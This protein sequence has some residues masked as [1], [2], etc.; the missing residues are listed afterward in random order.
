M[1]NAN[2]PILLVVIALVAVA[3]QFTR[4]SGE[5]PEQTALRQDMLA[6][7]QL[8][9]NQTGSQVELVPAGERV[10]VQA[11]VSMPPNLR[12]RQQRWN[13]PFL[14]FVALRHP[15][16]RLQNLEVLDG[17]TH[18]SVSE[19]ALNSL[20]ADRAVP[21]AN[22]DDAEGMSQLTARQMSSSLDRLLGVGQA[23]VLVDAELSQAS[24]ESVR[25]GG[26]DPGGLLAKRAYY[27]SPQ[28]RIT[29]MDVCVVVQ[30]EVP[31]ASWETFKSQQIAPYCK[32]RVVV[33]PKV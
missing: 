13:Y 16:V 3:A 2:F 27:P 29:R 4:H 23:L 1:K 33:L 19:V 6:S 7:L 24:R 32:L 5:K 25:Y 30:R 15:Q 26:P 8:L 18:R 11:L 28:D 22:Y 12:P 17:T 10:N 9:W 14:R 20:L 31:P 21:R